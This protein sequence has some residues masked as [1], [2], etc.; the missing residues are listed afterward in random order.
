MV[1]LLKISLKFQKFKA[2][3]LR[4]IS[5]IFNQ[6]FKL[7]NKKI[8]IISNPRKLKIIINNHKNNSQK[9]SKD[10]SLFLEDL[11]E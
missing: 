2:I 1:L 8:C 5:Y 4:N 10:L 9:F 11:L 6:K 7:I 3:Y